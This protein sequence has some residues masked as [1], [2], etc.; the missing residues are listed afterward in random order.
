[1]P[2]SKSLGTAIQRKAPEK[3]FESSRNPY[4]SY[5]PTRRPLRECR[6]E[7]RSVVILHPLEKTK[8]FRDQRF[9]GHEYEGEV[10]YKN[11]VLKS[12]SISYINGRKCGQIHTEI[13]LTYLMIKYRC[14]SSVS[15]I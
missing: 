14:G 1:M 3:L 11:R 10:D 13:S 9:P 15:V 5:F 4:G 6:G 12:G 7:E 8:V 2:R